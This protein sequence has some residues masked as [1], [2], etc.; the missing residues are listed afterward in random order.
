MKHRRRNNPFRLSEIA[1]EYL[2]K[3]RTVFVEGRLKTHKWQDVDTGTDRY[4]T[5]IIADQ[6]QM[7]GSRDNGHAETTQA[8]PAARPKG[9]SAKS[10]APAAESAEVDPSD[11]L[12]CLMKHWAG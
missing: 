12:F 11:I 7:L 6:M 8:T 1:G 5:E 10:K 9:R 2:R 4:N 3:G